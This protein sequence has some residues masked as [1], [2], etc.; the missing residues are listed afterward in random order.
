[1]KQHLR[2][3]HKYTKVL[4]ARK[5]PVRRLYSR[6]G[7]FF[8]RVAIED[9][10]GRSK[11]TWVPLEKAST[12]AQAQDE[13]ARV[14]VERQDNDLR[15]IGLSPTVE[16]Y[17][18]S[19]YEAALD[20]SGKK[21]DT[22]VTETGR[23][24]HWSDA[25]G[26]LRLDKIR[27]SHVQTVL[28]NLLKSGLQPRTCNG[29]LCAFNNLLKAARR[30]G[31]IKTLPTTGIARLKAEQVK[32]HL[33]TKVDIELICTKALLVSKNG[34]QFSDY[35]TFLMYTGAREKEALRI[36]WRDV[37]FKKKL[38]CIGADGDTKN[39]SARW[40]NMS[41]GL[42][43]HLQKME[44]GKAPDSVWLFPS[45]QRGEKDIHSQTFRESLLLARTEAKLEE[46]GFHD[47]R[48]YFISHAVMSGI[49]FMTIAKWVGH[50]DGGLLIGKV[51][52]HLSESHTKSQ[53][54]KMKFH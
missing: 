11:I 30:D 49:D 37:D 24:K 45:P 1:L 18:A 14:V 40:M 17:Y 26:H 19:S 48:H 32:R 16:S 46:F 35:L 2:R 41:P 53:A 38:L 3:R 27:P 4:D 5:R 31:Y 33:V 21:K 20:V 36:R 28:G 54:D 39:R 10:D 6:N 50:R 44:T 51:Y 43:T 47:C 12:V 25:I 23:L 15:H 34:V 22:I 29:C 9:E 8:A 13:L 52:G 7:K 42:E